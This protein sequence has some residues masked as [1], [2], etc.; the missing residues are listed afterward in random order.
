MLISTNIIFLLENLNKTVF[1]DVNSKFSHR[2]NTD[3]ALSDLNKAVE[4]DVNNSD[5][6]HWRGRIRRDRQECVEAMADFEAA[7]K[8]TGGYSA[9]AMTHVTS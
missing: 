3:E 5:Y 2:G 8:M 1:F 9:M 7:V 6:L 4:L